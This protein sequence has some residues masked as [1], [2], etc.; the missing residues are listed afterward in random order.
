MFVS[1]NDSTLILFNEGS[2]LSLVNNEKKKALREFCFYN[3]QIQLK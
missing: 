2:R 3:K 1:S